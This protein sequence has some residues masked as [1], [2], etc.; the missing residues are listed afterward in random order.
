MWA[1]EPM[2]FNVRSRT[3]E[4]GLHCYISPLTPGQ[5]PRECLYFCQ[6]CR[7]PQHS[8]VALRGLTSSASISSMIIEG[9]RRGGG[10]LSCEVAYVGLSSTSV[11]AP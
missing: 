11:K 3:V 7:M 10:F 5:K 2:C 1:G 8:I 4:L 9:P 6:M